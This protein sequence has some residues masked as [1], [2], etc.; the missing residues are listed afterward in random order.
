MKLSDKTQKNITID[1][2]RYN[3]ERII[4]DLCKT[5]NKAGNYYL[6]ASI[7]IVRRCDCVVIQ[8]INGD[9]ATIEK[10]N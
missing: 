10:S 5:P 7:E 6:N 1:G 2:K 9:F 8:S 4:K 3:Y